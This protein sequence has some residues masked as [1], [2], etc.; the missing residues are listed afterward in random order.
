MIVYT[1]D[2]S[3]DNLHG[4]WGVYSLSPYIGLPLTIVTIVGIVNAINLIDGVDGYSSGYCIMAC[5][6]VSSK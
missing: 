1:C 2:Y 3:I 5:F 6:D 4:L